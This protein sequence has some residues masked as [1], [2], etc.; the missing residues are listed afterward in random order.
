M[1]AKA[2]DLNPSELPPF[3]HI[4][5]A[6]TN[7][8]SAI[9]VNLF[10]ACRNIK[11]FMIQG[12]DPTGSG[13]ASGQPA[14]W[15]CSSCLQ[16]MTIHCSLHN[17]S[18]LLYRKLRLYCGLVAIL[19]PLSAG[20]GGKCIYPTSSGKFP[21]EISDN[22]KFSKRGVVA[23]ANSGPNTNGR[24][25]ACRPSLDALHIS[26]LT[27][28]V[29]VTGSASQPIIQSSAANIRMVLL[30]SQFFVSYAKA[31][32]LNGALRGSEPLCLAA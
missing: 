11:G 2:P 22:F 31:P 6:D 32:H 15:T 17:G 20:R 12:G 25:V 27:I 3:L 28:F 30:C 13:T 8:S 10:T 29:E 24:H 7:Q 14:K 1:K 4:V 16:G 21:D 19:F 23:M 26:P 9:S 18:S 5:S